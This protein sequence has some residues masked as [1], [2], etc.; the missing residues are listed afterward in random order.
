MQNSDV[1]FTEVE[2]LY[3]NTT[4]SM[5]KWMWHNHVQWVADK[6]RVLARKYGADS[7]KAYCAA[8]LHDLGDSHYERGHTDF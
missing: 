1:V 4:T 5:G 8:L 6:A 2:K 7:E 3:S